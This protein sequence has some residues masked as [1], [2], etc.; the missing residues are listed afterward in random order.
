MS[1]ETVRITF[2]GTVNNP[3]T[4]STCYIEFENKVLVFNPGI[5]V[6]VSGVVLPDLPLSKEVMGVI[7]TN[8][9]LEH[10]GALPIFWRSWNKP[11]IYLLD[12]P[13]NSIAFGNAIREGWEHYGVL[14]I[15]NSSDRLCEMNVEDL[16]DHIERVEL[17]KEVS[18]GPFKVR[19][20]PATFQKGVSAV[21]VEAGGFRIY[22][23]PQLGIKAGSA[24]GHLRR[25]PE[26]P[27]DVAIVDSVNVN[28]YYCD[29][30][31]AKRRVQKQIKKILLNGKSLLFVVPSGYRGVEL[32]DVILDGYD[33]GVIP[34]TSIY[35]DG[36]VKDLVKPDM[37]SE[38][39]ASKLRKYED[40]FVKVGGFG[41][42]NSILEFKKFPS[43]AFVSPAT[44][45]VTPSKEW[46][47]ECVN[48]ANVVVMVPA[49]DSYGLPFNLEKECCICFPD[50]FAHKVACEVLRYDYPQHHEGCGVLDVM[51]RVK[52]GIFIPMGATPEEFATL[53]FFADSMGIEIANVFRGSSIT[54][55][56]RE[57][58]VEDALSEVV[59]KTEN[60]KLVLEIGDLISTKIPSS[61]GELYVNVDGKLSKVKL[62]VIGHDAATSLGL[63]KIY[64]EKLKRLEELRRGPDFSVPE[65]IREEI[66]KLV[67]ILKKRKEGKSV[68]N[69]A[70]SI[71][72]PPTTARDRIELLKKTGAIEEFSDNYDKILEMNLLELAKWI[73]LRKV[74]DKA[75]ERIKEFEQKMGVTVVW[76]REEGKIM[77]EIGTNLL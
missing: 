39:V 66:E 41:R 2:G 73:P 23:A 27:V 61:V 1:K 57:K 31:D 48:S 34:Y 30:L 58:L 46:I 67:Y 51:M 18:I 38:P 35:L 21:L 55:T 14:G 69:V 64:E 29:I 42:N 63:R 8:P 47:S 40:L 36:G 52:P 72:V 62:R 32:L 17:Y 56:D 12:D 44:G 3:R 71:G 25:Y 43:I 49:Y 53:K 4:T 50:V 59:A 6:G 74:V 19:L 68:I 10:A 37:Y 33:S 65:D 20:Y 11:R 60:G 28:R 54:L 16:F 77:I 76:N 5:E 75:R 22:Y 45:L 26:Q 24:D 13:I 15:V 70:K 7:V 9:V